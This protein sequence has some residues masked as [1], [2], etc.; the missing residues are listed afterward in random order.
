[1]EILTFIIYLTFTLIGLILI[2]TIYSFNKMISLRNRSLNTFSQIEVLIR[3]RFTVIQNLEIILKAETKH[4]KTVFTSIAKI[5][6][7]AINGD[8]NI[9][10]DEI[11]T[12]NNASKQILMIS[13]AYPNLK[14][15]KSFTKFITEMKNCE[16]EIMRMRFVYN[17]VIETYNNY[18]MTFP[19][20]IF[21]KMFKFQTKKFLEL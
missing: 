21:A 2:Y 6:S 20:L 9:A 18:L 13:E 3:K 14:S 1:M 12:G 19:A 5:R 17:N 8:V 4:E 15:N 11:I 7:D 10:K 16:D